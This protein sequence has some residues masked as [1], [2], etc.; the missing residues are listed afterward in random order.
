LSGYI[1]R[2]LAFAALLVIV[3]SSTSMV[4][5]RL[6]PGDYVD[7]SLPPEA[8]AEAKAQARARLGL[9]RSIGAQYLDWLGAAV[10][11]DFG[12]SFLYDRPVRELIPARAANTAVLALTAL[13]VATLV[14]LPLGVVSGSRRGPLSGTIRFV[15]LVLLSMPPLL[16]SLFLVFVAA[17]TGWFPIGGIGES[18]G[19]R[20]HHLVLPAMAIGLPLAAVLERLQAQAMGEVIGAPFVLAAL[21]ARRDALARRLAFRA[22][23]VAPARSGCLRTDRRLAAQR[24]VRRRSDHRV[25]GAGQPDARRA[26]R[27]RH[28]SGHRLRRDG[29]VVPRVRHVVLGPGARRRGSTRQRARAGGRVKPAVARFR[30]CGASRSGRCPRCCHRGGRD[31]AVSRAARARRSRGS[32]AQRAANRAAPARRLRRVARAVH[33][34]LAARQPAASSGTSRTDRGLFRSRGCRTAGLVESSDDAHAP[35]ML[36]G[37][38]SFGRDVFSRCCSARGCRS[39]WQRSPRWERCS[40]GPRSAPPPATSAA[41]GTMC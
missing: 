1:V 15:S 17:R 29:G 6:A 8:S 2:R 36:L 7:L 12:R 22:Q 33:L 27:A 35:L 39:G 41:S 14:G 10:R 9:D 21:G 13:A 18:A 26:A 30:A 37:A 31:G 28:L 32:A 11:L 34:P 24:I 19:D 20:L 16:T 3:V 38:D 40:W 5:A 25:A 23:A 4:L